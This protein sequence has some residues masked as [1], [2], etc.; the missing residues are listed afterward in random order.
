MGVVYQAEDTEL[1]RFVALKFL[2]DEVAHDPQAFERFRREAR[3]ASALNHPNICTIYEIGEHEGK[4]FIAMEYLEGQTLKQ[5]IFNRP[6]ETERLLDL[7][8]EIA[9]A[10]DAAHSKGIVHR[11]IKP[12]NIFVTARGHAKILDFGL[13]KISPLAA[14][15]SGE[16]ATVANEHLTSPGST[17]GTVAY[18]S[19]EQALGK[20]LDSRTD[21]FSFGTVLYEM[22]TGTLP[23][24]GEAAAAIFNAILSKSP[25]PPVRLNADLPADLERLINK[26]LEKDRDI[27]YQSAAE[28]R[29]D[30]KRLKR[31]TVSGSV[32][33]HIP[34]S[35]DRRIPKAGGFRR[36]SMMLGLP[37][38]L[39]VTAGIFWLLF[40]TSPPKVTGSTQITHDGYPM[41]NMVTDGSRIYVTQFRPSGN[42]LAEVSVTGGETSVIPNSIANIQL[43]DISA[44]H[45]QLL[46]GS[47]VA[48]G[49]LERALWVLPLPAGAPRR[50]GDVVAYGAKWSPDGQ[51]LVFSK[52][53][54][55]Y[56]AKADGSNAHL[57][58]DMP[59]GFP[60]VAKFSP[61]GSR[62]RFTL[63]DRATNS[64]SLWEVRSDG[65]KLHQMFAGWHNPP[66]ECCGD[67]TADGRYYFFE[68]SS[69]N[70]GDNNIYALRESSNFFRKAS[71]TPVPLTTGPLLYF[72]AVPAPNGKKLF[73][74]GMQ[75]RGEAVRYD[76]VAKQFVPFIGGLPASD[77]AFSRDGKWVGYISIPDGTLWRSRLDGSEPLQLTYSPWTA[78]LPSWSPDGSQ[79]AYVAAQAGMPWKIYIVSVQGGAPE[80][81]LPEKT[82]EI[83]PTWSAD[84]KRLAFGRLGFGS[85]GGEIEIVDLKTREASV[86]PG[87]QGLFSPRWSPDGRYMAAL[88][89]DSKKVMVYD[90]NSQKWS[91]WIT[92][93]GNVG[94]PSWSSDS[95]YLYYDDFAG[96]PRY[97]RVKVGEHDPE[98]VVSLSK[99]K[100]YSGLWGAWSGLSPDNSPLFV[101]DTSTQEIYAL[102]L[103]LP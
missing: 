29:G 76:P 63:F 35:S 5:V 36:T 3:A 19:P 38:L 25:T 53:S 58:A 45:S 57:L 87:S 34:E 97:R 82:G 72:S 54:A 101:R 61:D 13:A 31:D 42:T 86:L 6:M 8:I 47:T 64:Q 21:L 80:E 75:P 46:A 26:A 94:Y 93:P 23:F 99:L 71:T 79:I 10:L 22:A 77:L 30:L 7:G 95:R 52:N 9:D 17:L 24:R 50:L 49:S 28:I 74:Q 103:D 48:T 15:S 2:P 11:D 41:A 56:M 102:D 1:G 32:T 16:T 92:D 68:V 18:M 91:Q 100:S 33:V 4:P 27:R 43:S 89:V 37:L 14:N 85:T 39:I 69:R 62:I 90:F 96:N 44:D 66:S 40:P 73:V 55:L 20:E 51:Q 88:T 59:K 60:T 84:G 98:D 83:D 65:T 81:L 67:W 12:A 78:S 70:G